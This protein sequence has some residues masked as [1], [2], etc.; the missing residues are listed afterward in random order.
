MAR[1]YIIENKNLSKPIK[2]VDFDE[3]ID[4]LEY[5]LPFI[6]NDTFGTVTEVNQKDDFYGENDLDQTIDGMN[7]GFKKN[8]DYFLEVIEDTKSFKDDANLMY[9][10]IEGFSY[11][12]GAVVSGVPECCINTGLPAPT[13]CFKIFVDI[14]FNWTY[15]AKQIM[16]RGIAITCL[17]E[18]LILNGYIVDLYVMDFNRQSDIHTMYTVKVD[19]QN[20]SIANIAFMSSPEY[21]RKI[22]WITTDK[23]RN[24][25]S[26]GG[27]GNST[28]L[29]FMLDKIKKDKIFYIG[30]SYTDSDLCNHLSTPQEAIK[31]LV[32]KF[33]TFCKDNKIYVNL[34]IKEKNSDI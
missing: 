25:A 34:D 3:F 14:T 24:K 23:I 30:G 29:P 8:T 5:I 12:M 6:K 11:D 33:N 21:F 13:P 16:N 20:L 22:G 31:Y 9:M 10:D 15:S 28:L 17:I 27:R 2:C 1:E 32:N 4:Q 18:N 26:E 7:Y 19:T